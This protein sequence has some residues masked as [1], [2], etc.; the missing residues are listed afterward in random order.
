M[1]NSTYQI[2]F[3]LSTIQRKIFFNTFLIQ[4]EYFNSIT[5]LNTKPQT[6]QHISYRIL[7]HS[8]QPLEIQ[9]LYENYTSKPHFITFSLLCL[10]NHLILSLL[11]AHVYTNLASYCQSEHNSAITDIYPRSRGQRFESPCALKML[12]KKSYIFVSFLFILDTFISLLS[13]HED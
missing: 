12:K 5:Q 7:L 13:I 4:H 10:S 9:T 1:C 11:L 6:L 3:C 8:S 2:P